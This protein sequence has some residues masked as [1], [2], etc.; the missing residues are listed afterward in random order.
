MDTGWFRHANTTPLTFALAERLVAAGAAPTPIYDDLFER[1]TLARLKL[2]GRVLDRLAAVAGGRV[3]LSEVRFAD[4]AETGAVPLDTEDLVNDLSVVG[5]E[6]RLLFLEQRDGS[7]KV[8]FRSRRADVARLAEQFGGGGHRLASG[9]TV[10]GP[11][12]AARERVL[13]AVV[14]AVE[15]LPAAERGV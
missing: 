12:G 11:L 3:A 6:V 15:L 7:V 1:N 9:A 13:Q 14:A 10:P 2:R 4:Y 8:S 5:V